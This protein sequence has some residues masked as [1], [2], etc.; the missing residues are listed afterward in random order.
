VNEIKGSGEQEIDSYGEN[1][2]LMNEA[3]AN[4]AVK[5]HAYKSE[6]GKKSIVITSCGTESGTTTI[7]TRLAVA[8]SRFGYETLLVDADLRTLTKDKDRRANQGLCDI[9]SYGYEF[10]KLIKLTTADNLSFMPS[11]NYTGD[12]TLLFCSDKMS[13]FIDKVSETYEFVIIDCPAVTV[14]PDAMALFPLVDGIILVCALDKTRKEQLKTSKTII[15]PY[16][17]KY[18]GLVVNSVDEQQYKRMIKE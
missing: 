17:D 4:L 5:V 12:P 11:G 7:A 6:Y 8:L 10:D 14:A 15:E 16:A 3:I 13:A 9:I 2:K 1:D 18:Y